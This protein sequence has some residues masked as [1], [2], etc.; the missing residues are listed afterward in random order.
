MFWLNNAK[1][2]P[3]IGVQ[4]L[5]CWCIQ[6]ECHH[7]PKQTPVPSNSIYADTCLS[8]TATILFLYPPGSF[9][10][11]H[12]SFSNIQGL[13]HNMKTYTLWGNVSF[14][15]NIWTTEHVGCFPFARGLPLKYFLSP[16]L[17]QCNGYNTANLYNPKESQK[18]KK[19]YT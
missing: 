16:Q 13:W 14:G 5:I 3:M 9:F 11:K 15:W 19:M 2:N 18:K 7:S 17:S 1:K 10:I 6:R 12:F 4:N 8:N